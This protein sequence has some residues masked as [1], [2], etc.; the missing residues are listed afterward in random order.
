MTYLRILDAIGN[1]G[2]TTLGQAIDRDMVTGLIASNA[3]H[4]RLRELRP[5]DVP[6]E[7]DFLDLGCDKG[8]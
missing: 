2:G 1:F 6:P 7:V 8:L 4:A 5:G 3:G